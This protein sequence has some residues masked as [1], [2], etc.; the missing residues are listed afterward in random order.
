MRDDITFNRLYEEWSVIDR[1][2]GTTSIDAS[3]GVHGDRI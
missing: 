3:N 2:D 1:L